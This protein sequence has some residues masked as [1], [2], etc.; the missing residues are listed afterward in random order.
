[1]QS[2]CSRRVLAS[3]D[4]AQIEECSCGSMHLTIGAVTL[5]LQPDAL[6]ALATVIG[7]AARTFVLDNALRTQRDELLS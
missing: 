6:P 1:M 5:R 4:F 3:G 7:N 2:S